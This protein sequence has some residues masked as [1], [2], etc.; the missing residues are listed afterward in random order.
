MA[1][2][3]Q[4]IFR[5]LTQLFRSGPVVRRKVRDYEGSSKSSTAFEIFRKTQNESL[6]RFL[7]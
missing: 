6:Q 5:R 7:F 4:N 1:D 3:S 2:N